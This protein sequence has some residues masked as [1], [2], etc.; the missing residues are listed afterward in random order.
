LEMKPS[1][2]RGTANNALEPTR[3]SLRSCLAPAIACGSP[4]ALASWRKTE[5]Q[6]RQASVA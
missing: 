6:Q 1:V 4:L 3:N 2:S 5:E